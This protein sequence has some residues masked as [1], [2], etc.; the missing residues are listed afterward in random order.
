MQRVVFLG[1]GG[2][3]GQVECLWPVPLN[4]S[5][6]QAVVPTQL[7]LLGEDA[8]QRVSASRGATPSSCGAGKPGRAP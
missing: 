1:L 7:M 8:E 3:E 4:D 5:Q 2:K 6:E